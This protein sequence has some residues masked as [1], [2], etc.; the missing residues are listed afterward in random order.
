MLVIE[1]KKDENIERALRRYKKKYERTKVLR[2]LRGRMYYKKPTLAKKEKMN[3][4]VRRE[5]ILRQMEY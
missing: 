4:A 1:V 5:Q 2:K 3:K